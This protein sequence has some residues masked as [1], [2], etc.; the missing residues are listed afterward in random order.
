MTDISTDYIGFAGSD[1]LC[2]DHIQYVQI[3]MGSS[4]GC[5]FVN[6]FCSNRGDH[7]NRAICLLRDLKYTVM[8]GE[9]YTFFAPCSLG[10]DSNRCFFAADVF[11]SLIDGDNGIA[12]IFPVNGQKADPPYHPANE[13]N[14]K[15]G[16]LGYES[17]L[18]T[19][20]D[21]PHD[22]GIKIGAVVADKQHQLIF[23]NFLKS[24]NMDFDSGQLDDK[25]DDRF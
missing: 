16:G 13:R 11:C 24:G 2:G 21:V 15:I 8:K 19:I 20:E 9:K 1:H 5:S 18:P 25:K 14:S 22:D 6:R 23:G 4:E 7:N 3:N 17:Q 12:G 10:V